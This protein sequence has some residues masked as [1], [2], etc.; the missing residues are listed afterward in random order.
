MFPPIALTYLDI[1]ERLPPPAHP[2]SR[3]WVKRLCNRAYLSPILPA[4]VCRSLNQIFERSASHGRCGLKLQT[5]T[6]A[7][8]L[9]SLPF[10]LSFLPF[11]RRV[12][13]VFYGRALCHP[14]HLLLSHLFGWN[15]G[16]FSLIMVAYLQFQQL[17]R[18]FGRLF[19]YSLV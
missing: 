9:R 13:V 8:H 3:S 15:F 19:L 5:V 1:P 10:L 11:I 6:P 18:P 7:P 4:R 17:Y 12:R 2:P 14:Y 16:A